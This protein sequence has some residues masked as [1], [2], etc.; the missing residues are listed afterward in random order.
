MLSSQL[1]DRFWSCWS[2]EYIRNLPP[3]K[4]CLSPSRGVQIGSL[5]LIRDEATN[6]LQWPLGIVKNVHPGRDGVVRVVDVKTH[7]GIL[8]RPIQRIYCL[9]VFQPPESLCSDIALLQIQRLLSHQG[10]GVR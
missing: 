4:G 1:L 6:R 2:Q 7:K 9:E 8:T 10:Q 5:V 3:F